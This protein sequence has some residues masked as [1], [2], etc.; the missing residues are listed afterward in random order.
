M[1]VFEYVAVDQTGQEVRGRLTADAMRGAVA[2]LRGQ[3]VFVTEI[4]EVAET[5]DGRGLAREIDLSH[6]RSVRGQDVVFFFQQMAFILRAGLPVLQ[7]LQLSRTQVSS[8]RLRKVIGEMIADIEAGQALSQTM[9]RHPQV[10]TSLMVNMVMAGE[11]TGELDVVMERIA[12]H[13]EQ[14]LALRAQVLNAMIYPAVVVLAT[15]GVSIFLV[16]KVIPQFEKFIVGRGKS[17]PASTQALL[18]ISH[19]LRDN[20]W[21]IVG[22]VVSVAVALAL[23][24][25]TPP[26]R[27]MLDGVLL[28]LPVLG[29]LLTNGAMAELTWSLANLV[30]SGLTVREGLLITAGVVRNRVISDKLYATSDLILEGRDLSGSL[31][32]PAIPE[33]VTQ[34]IAVGERTGT[35][36][37]VLTELARHYERLLQNGIKR[38][39]AMVEPAMILIIGGM[40]GFVYYAFFQ[41]L[42]KLAG[43]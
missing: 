18:D 41:A 26:G 5:Q 20:V 23:T 13:V 39:S 38:L 31:R 1:P 3:R 16:W 40:V 28:R 19:F 35:L 12:Q 10:F 37:H 14:A 7:G 21:W 36:D 29:K 15:I 4:R 6:W 8:G 32:H 25:R 27:L 24:Y 30:K 34:M 2:E 43:R 17:L 11:S 9:R 42:F 33:L 22:A